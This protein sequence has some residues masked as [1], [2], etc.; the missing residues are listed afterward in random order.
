MSHDNVLEL[1]NPGVSRRGSRRAERGTAGW[2]ADAAMGPYLRSSLSTKNWAI[3]KHSAI[4]S[5]ANCS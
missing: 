1:R 3:G 2:R 5:C 4:V